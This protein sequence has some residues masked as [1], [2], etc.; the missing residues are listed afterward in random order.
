MQIKR[1]STQFIERSV[2]IA[3]LADVPRVDALGPV[4]ARFLYSLR[5]IA[6][7]DRAGHDPIPELAVRLASVETAAK[8]LDLANMITMLWA[9]NV[10][11]SRFCCQLLTHDEATIGALVDAACDQDR[12]KFDANIDG[13]IRPARSERLW[14]ATIELVGAE[15]RV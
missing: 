8:A 7:Y 11:L 15:M 10:H 6:I 3:K 4:A 9:E 5:L 2:T 14:L 13:L 12:A 1:K